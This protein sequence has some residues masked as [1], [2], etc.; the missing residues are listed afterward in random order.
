MNN[1]KQE[2]KYKTT[3]GH[4][5]TLPVVPDEKTGELKRM[6]APFLAFTKNN[7]PAI[8]KLSK[9]NPMASAILL[10]LIENMDNT[11]ALIVSYQTL[12]EHF[13]RSRPVLSKYIKYLNENNYIKIMKSG[14]MNIYCINAQI[15]WNQSQ[16]KIHFAKF[17]ATVYMSLIHI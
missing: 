7:F 5:N 12:C 4:G 3:D 14:N 6:K 13:G 2:N 1:I 17:N 8:T 9:D 10:F 11:N 15:V 16:E